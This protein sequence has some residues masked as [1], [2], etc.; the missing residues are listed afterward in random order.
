MVVIDATILLLILNPHAPGPKDASGNPVPYARERIAYLIKEL[1]RT[2]TQIGIPA[3]ALSEILVRMGL[4]K[5]HETIAYLEQS[6]VFSVEA[7]DQMA[8]IE[9]AEMLKNE[10]AQNRKRARAGG[11]ETYAKLKFDRQVVAISKVRGAKAIYSDDEHIEILGRQN[12]I[13]V[14]GVKGLELPPEEHQI[15]LLPHESLPDAG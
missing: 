3:P 9:L 7:F 4:N 12:G 15:P 1:Q 2:K 10:S 8:A 5:A 6:A 14:V 11:A 13:K